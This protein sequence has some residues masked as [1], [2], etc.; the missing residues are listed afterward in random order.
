VLAQT[1]F[2]FYGNRGM[3]FEIVRNEIG[4]AD[5]FSSTTPRI[6]AVDDDRE[7]RQSL[8]KIFQKAGFQVHVA[9]DG[10]QA[11]ALLGKAHYDLVILDLKLPGK[12]GL[13]LLREI[14]TTMPDTRVIVVTSYG[15]AASRFEAMAAGA[16]EYLNKPVKRNAI[17]GA[18]QRA[19]MHFSKAG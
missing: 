18:S 4:D 10:S 13:E 1:V 3:L 8:I 16:F 5:M 11:V 14:K 9:A 12:S 19:L 2:L 17:L 7:F 6:L 15:D